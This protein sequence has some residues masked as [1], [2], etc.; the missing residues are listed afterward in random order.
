MSLAN[1]IG[2]LLI[3]AFFKS[4]NSLMTS[5]IFIETDTYKRR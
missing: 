5:L 3:L 1:L 4:V 2:A